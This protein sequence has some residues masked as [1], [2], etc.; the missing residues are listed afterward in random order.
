[1]TCWIGLEPGLIDALGTAALELGGVCDRLAGG[2][3]AP[4][5]PLLGQ[6]RHSAISPMTTAMTT[7]ARRRAIWLRVGRRRFDR[8]MIGGPFCTARVYPWASAL[9]TDRSD[10][11]RRPSDRAFR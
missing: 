7:L 11:S 2:A 3:A 1:M 4:A 9:R 8:R 6:N 10:P 5:L